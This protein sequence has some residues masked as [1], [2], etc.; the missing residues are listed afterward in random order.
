M[1][2]HAR[3]P[4]EL[5]GYSKNANQDVASGSPAQDEIRFTQNTSGFDKIVFQTNDRSNP[6]VAPANPYR[7]Y[8]E[9]AYSAA[10]QPVAPQ[11]AYAANG[12]VPADRAYAASNPVGTPSYGVQ[13]QGNAAF[14]GQPAEAYGGLWTDEQATGKRRKKRRGLKLFLGIVGVLLLVVVAVCG[15]YIHEFDSRVESNQSTPAEMK[16]V[17]TPATPGEPYYVLLLGSD[18]RENTGTSKRSDQSGDNQRSDVIILTRIDEA[19]NQVTLVTVPRDT[20]WEHDGTVSKINETYNIGGA[21][22]TTKV[23]SEITGTPIA[24][25][26]EIHF[27]GLEGLVDALGGVKVDVPKNIKYWDALT[28]ETIRL[29]AGEQ[30]LNGQQAQIFARV[31]KAYAEQEGQRQ[32]NVRSLVLAIANELRSKPLYEYPG[33]GLEIANCFGSDMRFFDFARLLYSFMGDSLTM[34]SATG[35]NKGDIDAGTGLWLCYKNPEGWQRLMD[36]VNAGEDPASVDVNAGYENQGTENTEIFEG[37]AVYLDEGAEEQWEAL[38]YPE[39]WVPEP[40]WVYEQDA[41]QAYEPEQSDAYLDEQPIQANEP[42]V[43]QESLADDVQANAGV[44][45]ETVLVDS[46][47]AAD[48]VEGGQEE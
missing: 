23:V 13:G 15:L 45:A 33:L 39:T 41:E 38:P 19:N 2:K 24:H 46:G 37:D 11:N 3:N 14:T 28:N 25:T 27:S 21:A 47:A 43:M 29:E 42:E 40:E 4:E 36:V 1:A 26:V 9:N 16:D 30:V 7:S 18:W 48:A 10:G 35:P 5:D 17:L 44:D 34:Y 6:Y 20:P 12:A 22:L 31:R 8:S 32:S